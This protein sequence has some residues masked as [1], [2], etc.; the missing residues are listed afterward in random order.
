MF[1]SPQ[2]VR[3]SVT[4]AQLVSRQDQEGSPSRALQ[5]RTTPLP[6]PWLS[7]SFSLLENSLS[8]CRFV[9]HPASKPLFS[10]L[11][12]PEYI[13]SLYPHVLRMATPCSTLLKS[14]PFHQTGCLE[15]LLSW[16][17]TLLCRL[18]CRPSSLPYPSLNPSP[19]VQNTGFL[20]MDTKIR[21]VHVLVYKQYRP[22]YPPELIL[23]E[24]WNIHSSEISPL[25]THFFNPDHIWNSDS[26]HL[27]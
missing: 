4:E 10:C 14:F 18:V 11:E 17:P 3:R 19:L 15:F 13:S 12:P 1:F 23:S 22:S 26:F 9:F 20:I 8:L 2:M 7:Q 5:D 24:R 27:I 16:L 21:F 6:T 25:S